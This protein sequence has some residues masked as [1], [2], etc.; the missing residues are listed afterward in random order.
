[1]GTQIDKKNLLY[2]WSH[3]LK[4]TF[5]VIMDQVKQPVR[6]INQMKACVSIH[7]QLLWFTMV[8]G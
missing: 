4:S 7:D 2:Q 1:M 6:T 8:F 3:S 5:R